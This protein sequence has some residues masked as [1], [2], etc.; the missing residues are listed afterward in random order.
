MYLRTAGLTSE[1]IPYLPL[2]TPILI[3]RAGSINKC[4]FAF[5]FSRIFKD[6]MNR[7]CAFGFAIKC[8]ANGNGKDRLP[9][10]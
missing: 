4:A 7:K 3:V 2:K 6:Q 1:F 10:S 8:N 5:A 9:G